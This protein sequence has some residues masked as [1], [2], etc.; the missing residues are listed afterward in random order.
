MFD[1]PMW[2]SDSDLP[3]QFRI[4]K[5]ETEH[6]KSKRSKPTILVVDDE[7][8][9]AETTGEILKR[10]GFHALTAFDGNTAL[11]LALQF[12]P[13]LVLTDI[14]MPKMNGVDLA[15][16]IRKSLPKTEILLLSGQAGISDLL[17][18]GRD[19]GYSFELIGKPVHPE[20]ILEW[21]RKTLL[22]K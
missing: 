20:T 4:D 21:I 7:R 16:A 18:N 8:L 11:G 12:Q 3:N 15:I 17:E 5:P 1:L 22:N 6:T 2:A 14:V 9:I 13:D 10:A 19:Q